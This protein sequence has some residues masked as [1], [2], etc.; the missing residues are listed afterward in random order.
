MHRRRLPRA[1]VLHPFAKPSSC[2]VWPLRMSASASVLDPRTC[3]PLT[4]PPDQLYQLIY[5]PSQLMLPALGLAPP[6]PVL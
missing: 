4:S 5:C 2:P 1:P 6:P 3:H